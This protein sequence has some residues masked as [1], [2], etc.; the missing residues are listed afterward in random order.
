MERNQAFVFCPRS[1]P[2]TT[3]RFGPRRLASHGVRRRP[4]VTNHCEPARNSTIP[5]PRACAGTRERRL[6]VGRGPPG[7][8]NQPHLLAGARG[9]WPT[10]RRSPTFPAGVRL[11]QWNSMIAIFSWQLYRPPLAPQLRV[12]MR[13]QH[14]PLAATLGQ[15]SPTLKPALTHAFP[16]K[17]TSSNT[18]EPDF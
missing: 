7:A 16:P 18:P 9:G 13:V 15:H 3:S 17:P 4:V 1:V 11:G 8:A 10:G 6:G 2:R 12:R 5:L 14:C